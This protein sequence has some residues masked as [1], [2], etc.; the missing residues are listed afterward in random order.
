MR[1]PAVSAFD[2]PPEQFA[3]NPAARCFASLRDVFSMNS[4]VDDA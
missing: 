4:T 3:N 2:Y 1:H